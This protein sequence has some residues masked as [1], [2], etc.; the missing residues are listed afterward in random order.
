[1]ITYEMS[2]SNVTVTTKCYNN[3]D[4]FEMSHDKN[5]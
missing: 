5:S 4:T 1:M 3:Y 2:D